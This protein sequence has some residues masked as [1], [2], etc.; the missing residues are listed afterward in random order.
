L[1]QFQ[2]A[3]SSAARAEAHSIVVAGRNGTRT[4]SRDAI[5]PSRVAQLRRCASKPRSSRPTAV[6]PRLLRRFGP[7]S[8][9]PLEI[10]EVVVHLLKCK[11]QCEEAFRRIAWKSSCETFA[12]K[13]N[14]LGSISSESRFHKA[15]GRR[16]PTL[17]QRRRTAPQV[18]CYS[19]FGM[20]ERR[21][22]P[23]CE[24]LWQRNDGRSSEHYK[25]MVQPEQGCATAAPCRALRRDAST[26]RPRRRRPA[27]ST[28]PKPDRCHRECG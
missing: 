27:H 14:D 26:A 11:P 15:K 23:T 16:T 21:Y 5:A 20:R 9:A 7:L 17:L 24:C 6:A 1:S 12:T 18:I 10:F 4:R 2:S 8:H 19:H 3:N 22:E 25:V 28:A 13:R